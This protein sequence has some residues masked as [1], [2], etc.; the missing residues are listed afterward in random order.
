MKL[1]STHKLKFLYTSPYIKMRYYMQTMQTDFGALGTTFLPT[2]YSE[3]Q[4]ASTANE[5]IYSTT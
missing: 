1:L 2:L 4:S 5:I 3:T